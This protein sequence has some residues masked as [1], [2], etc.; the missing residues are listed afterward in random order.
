MPDNGKT[1]DAN[2]TMGDDNDP[3]TYDDETLD[4]HYITGDGRGNENIGLTAVHHVFHSEH[5][6]V[7]EQ[8][9]SLVN[10]HI[11]EDP[12]FVA[13]WRL[14]AGAGGWNGERLFQAARLVT[15]ME[16]QHL[17]FEEFARKI[18]PAIEVLPRNESGYSPIINPAISAEF[19]TW[20]TGSGT[21]C[22][23]RTCAESWPMARQ[24]T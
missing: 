11:A 4:A 5:N 6:R 8:V 3:S 9:K 12:A 10:D 7:V 16:Y 13:E 15:E 23:R 20:S 2:T 21:R 22:S 17:V 18:T 1:P 19:A 24:P 14:G